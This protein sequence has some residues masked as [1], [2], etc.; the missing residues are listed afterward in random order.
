M[1]LQL[2]QQQKDAGKKDDKLYKSALKRTMTLKAWQKKEIERGAGAATA[3][4]IQFNLPLE[5][6]T[7]VSS[8]KSK[9]TCASRQARKGT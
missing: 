1:I 3:D 6:V 7:L 8:E 4:T 9:T 5:Q 2:Q